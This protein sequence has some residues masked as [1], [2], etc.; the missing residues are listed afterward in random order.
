MTPEAL[1]REKARLRSAR[2]AERRALPAAVRAK[3]AEALARLLLSLPVWRE[4]ETVLAYAALP[5]EPDLA[6][7]LRALLSSGR[8]LALPRCE[9]DRLVPCLVPSLSRLRPGAFG[10]PEP[11]GSCPP[12]DPAAIRL[13]LVPGLAFDREGFRLGRGGGFYDR[14]LPGTRAFRVGVCREADFLPR[15]PREPWDARAD[16]V[17]TPGGF[18]LC[19]AEP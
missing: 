1:R 11:D 3:E 16:A 19:R 2:L 18:R 8:R 5:D 6:P 4:A 17:L 12:A 9:G 10:I 14:F 7:A 13:A 15:L